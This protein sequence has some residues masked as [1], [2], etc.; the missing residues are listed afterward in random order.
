MT[1]LLTT[2]EKPRTL[3]PAIADI[4]K[5]AC[6]SC[7]LF[8]ADICGGKTSSEAP[9]PPPQEVG[10]G[11]EVVV[12]RRSYSELLQ[13]DSVATVWAKPKPKIVANKPAIRPK[14]KMQIQRKPVAAA[15][16]ET[17]GEAVASMVYALF[18]IK[19]MRSSLKK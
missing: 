10:G 14:P 5:V 16:H 3:T 13:D 18:G 2:I 1:E 7:P 15:S 4:G 8:R 11:G 6:L 19:S 17:I 9:C 12:P